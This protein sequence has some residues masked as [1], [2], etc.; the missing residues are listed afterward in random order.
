MLGMRPKAS[1]TV[2]GAAAGAADAGRARPRVAPPGAL[3]LFVLERNAVR[4]ARLARRRAQRPGAPRR[5][6]L[7]GP[8]GPQ[9]HPSG[10]SSTSATARPSVG[11]RPAEP[12]QSGWLI[13]G[14]FQSTNGTSS[15]ADPADGD[16]PGQ[17][18]RDRRLLRRRPMITTEPPRTAVAIL[19]LEFDMG[20]AVRLRHDAG[21]HGGQ[22]LRLPAGRHA[23]RLPRRLRELRV[24][25]AE[26][27]AAASACPAD[28]ARPRSARQY[29]DLRRDRAAR[30]PAR[31]APAEDVE[32]RVGRV[33]PPTRTPGRPRGA[34]RQLPRAARPRRPR[35][36]LRGPVDPVPGRRRRGG[37]RRRAT[38]TRAPGPRRP[39]GAAGGMTP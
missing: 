26:A 18:A 20:D 34:A 7:R 16:C 2:A 8:G 37:R 21:A 9:P 15:V 32:V 23:G 4:P 28:R 30:R 22:R 38:S 25:A 3:V 19:A 36:Q 11:S 35:R 17:A 6:H 29:R 24:R 10:S 31:P 39:R 33:G 27:T 14:D 13:N 1:D 5:R 12:R